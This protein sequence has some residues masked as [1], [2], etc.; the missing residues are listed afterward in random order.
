[1]TSK[2][3][4]SRDFDHS[5][6]VL[7]RLQWSLLCINETVHWNN[8]L[9]SYRHA[10][11]SVNYLDL[12]Y[13]DLL[14]TTNACAEGMADDFHSTFGWSAGKTTWSHPVLKHTRSI[15]GKICELKSNKSIVCHFL[16]WAASV[17][18]DTQTRARTHTHTAIIKSI[19]IIT[20]QYHACTC[21]MITQARNVNVKSCL[22]RCTM[23][24]LML[25]HVCKYIPPNN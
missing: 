4:F 21:T 2:C 13:L 14:G 1:M 5:K 23:Q 18:T 24:L 3:W 16:L 17:V 15:F 11:N 25:V 8:A 12:N 22:E 7:L 20:S 10:V 19:P 9:L 6:Y